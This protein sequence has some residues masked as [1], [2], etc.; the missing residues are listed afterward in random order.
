MDE[1]AAP[2]VP[3]Y[4]QAHKLLQKRLETAVPAQS[5]I[6]DYRRRYKKMNIS[7][8]V[9]IPATFSASQFVLGIEGFLMR[10]ISPKL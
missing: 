2:A 6:D 4:R 3:Q 10:T 7:W 8:F 5:V 1:I 9:T